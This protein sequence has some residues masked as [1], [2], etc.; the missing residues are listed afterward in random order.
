MND[1]V[2]PD[3]E[4][5][6]ENLPLLPTKTS[7][8]EGISPPSDQAPLPPPAKSYVSTSISEFSNVSVEPRVPDSVNDI[9]YFTTTTNPAHPSSSSNDTS[10][11]SAFTSNPGSDAPHTSGPLAPTAIKPRPR[12]KPRFSKPAIETL[13]VSNPLDTSISSFTNTTAATDDATRLPHTASDSLSNDHLSSDRRDVAHLR[14]NKASSRGRSTSSSAVINISSDSE[15][16]S[17]EWH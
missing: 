17:G 13:E 7:P 15:D 11:L 9:S 16:G 3:S 6:A 2:I 8:F 12:P 4:D 5:E 10:P 14:D 1:E